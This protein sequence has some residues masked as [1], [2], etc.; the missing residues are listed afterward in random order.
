MTPNQWTGIVSQIFGSVAGIA[1]AAA[2]ILLISGQQNVVAAGL[3]GGSLGYF[4]GLL[5]QMAWRP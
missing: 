3:L 2:I 5:G 4:G 1:L